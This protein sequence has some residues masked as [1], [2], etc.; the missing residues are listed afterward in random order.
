VPGPLIAIWSP[1]G[2]VGK[3][4]IAAGLAMHVGRWS[5]TSTLLID[6]DAGKA[7]VAPL[8]QTGMRPNILD[9]PSGDGRTVKHPS[10]L[11]VLPGPAR[12]IDEGLVTG[13]LTEAVLQKARSQYSTIILDLDGDLRD[14][15]VVAMEK[16]DAVLLVVTPDLLSLYPARRFVQEAD[17]IGISLAKFRLVINRATERQEIP[18]A[19]I[20]NLIGLPLVG[21]I[22]N[23][24]GLAAS[25]NRGMTSA[26]MRSNTEFAAALYRLTENLQFLGLTCSPLNAVTTPLVTAQPG[27][28]PALKRWWRNL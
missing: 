26:T 24:P 14:S 1:K 17:L 25:I 23:L 8:L 22:P 28:L 10:G 21:Q 12:L 6:L 16:A 5:N 15:T 2:G 3:T 4:V 27:L 19:E 11:Q 7:D 20:Q 18:E 9:Y 13:A